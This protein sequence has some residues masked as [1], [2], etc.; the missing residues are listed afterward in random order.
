[1]GTQDI[2]IGLDGKVQ[3]LVKETKVNLMK[4]KPIL[5]C[6]DGEINVKN[7]INELED[8]PF[9]DL[10]EDFIK[11]VE[12]IEE[13]TEIDELERDFDDTSIKRSCPSGKDMV[14]TAVGVAIISMGI[15]VVMNK[16]LKDK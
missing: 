11:S 12:F 13:L 5:F 3:A 14:K 2:V 4:Q 8:D 10:E 1:M 9:G 15:L 7:V 6:K 16:L